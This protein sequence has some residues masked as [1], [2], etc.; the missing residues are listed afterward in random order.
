MTQIMLFNA[1][2]TVM[3]S[4]SHNYLEDYLGWGMMKG[5]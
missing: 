5:T 1:I 3:F 2:V 4:Y